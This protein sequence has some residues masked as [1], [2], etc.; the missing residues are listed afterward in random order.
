MRYRKL[1]MPFALCVE[2]FFQFEEEVRETIT[3]VFEK[4]RSDQDVF[5]KICRSR[6]EVSPILRAEISM[7]LKSVY[8]RQ[9]AQM[10]AREP[11]MV[12]FT[13]TCPL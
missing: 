9:T 8:R 2:N 6:I 7:V 11:W 3:S 10:K 4:Q 12:T 5:G 1:F 13:R